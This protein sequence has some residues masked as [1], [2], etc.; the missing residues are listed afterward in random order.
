MNIVDAIA[1]GRRSFP[2]KPA[3]RFDSEVYTYRQLD[4]YGSCMANLLAELGI[5]RGER[6]ALLLPNSPAFVFSYIGALKLGA[7]VVAINTAFKREEIGFILSDSGARVLITTAE[8]RGL[9]E[10][11]GASCEHLILADA[12]GAIQAAAVSERPPAALDSGDPAVILYTSGTTG[13]PKGAVLSH[14]NVLGNVRACVQAFGLVPEDRVLLCLPAFHCFG[15]NAVL[16]PCFEAGATL[17]LK[18]RFE[19]ET[20]LNSIEAE[21]ITVFFGVPTLYRI[22]YEEAAPGRLSSIRRYVSAA[23]GLPPELGRQWRS[24]FGLAVNQGYGLTEA[25]LACFNPDPDSD[26]VGLPLPGVALKVVDPGGLELPA[27][28]PGELAIQGPS[29]MQGYWKR[30]EATLEVL[31]EGWLHT[32]DIGRIDEA[33]RVYLVDRLKDLVN[34]GGM[35]VTPAEVEQVLALHP[36]VAEAA[37]YGVADA[38]LGEQV[39]ASVVLRPEWTA[40]AAELTAFCRERL[41]EFKLPG[42]IDFVAALPK[43]GT[44]KILKRL[45]REREPAAVQG[46]EV[47]AAAPDVEALETWIGAWLSRELGLAAPERDRPFADLGLTSVQAVR[48]ATALGDWLGRPLPAVITWSFPTLAKLAR[49]LAPVESQAPPPGAPE[50]PEVLESLSETELAELLA[51]EIRLAQA[52]RSR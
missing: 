25:C 44:G 34:V 5:G 32:G 47:P 3:L 31:R 36:A 16:N 4:E 13:L 45:L 2:E 39:R 29:V 48:L 33:G 37:V 42:A 43:S 18:P 22:L 7:I 15:Q 28:E 8:W 14:G 17:V 27:G 21:G 40:D 49:R 52:R 1:R 50:P 23:A 35:K 24:R 10:D 30:P 26:S 51:A 46:A 19:L 9:A 20:V 12:A 6:V 11:A 38:L 41:A